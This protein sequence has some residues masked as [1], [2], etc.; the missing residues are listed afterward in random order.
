MGRELEQSIDSIAHEILDEVNALEATQVQIEIEQAKTL[1]E[2]EVKKS[3]LT[4]K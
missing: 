2:Y 1:A 4:E 3:E